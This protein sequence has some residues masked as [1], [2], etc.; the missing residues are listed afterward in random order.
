MT[1]ALWC[2]VIGGVLVVMAL[3]GSVVRRLPLSAAMLYMGIGYGLGPAGA[4][5]LVVDPVADAR[6][7]EH[8]TE[9]AV[10]VSLFTAGL[11]LRAPLSDRLWRIPVLLA[12]ASMAVGVGLVAA[13]AV[14]ALGLPV[15]AAV[16]LGAVLAPTDPVLAADVQ[17]KDAG[18]RDELRFSLTAEAGLNDGT[19]FPFVMLGLGLLGLHDLGG[20]WWRWWTIDVAWAAAAGLG[21][22]FGLGTL[23]ARVV[24]YLRKTH[25]EAVG[26]D[27]FLAL[28]LLGLAYGAAVLL[29]AWGFLS[30]FAAGLAL[31]REEMRHTAA[32][33]VEEITSGSEDDAVHPDKAPMV[34]AEAV[35][36]FNEQVEKVLEVAAVLVLGALLAATRPTWAAAGLAATLFLVVRPASVFAG[37][38]PVP[39]SA[40]RRWL[41]GWFGVRGVGSLYYSLT[42]PAMGYRGGWPG[43]WP[44]WWCGPSPCRSSCMG[45]RSHRRWTGT[46]RG[47]SGGES[48]KR[49]DPTTSPRSRACSSVPR[50]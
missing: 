4:G 32:W 27:N 38:A 23:V 26:L 33:P 9:L 35:L 31:R 29:G 22:G 21:V 42:P 12:T 3:A 41:A 45:C 13:V 30:A 36:R 50:G 10:I 18:D 49:P 28:G 11:K 43:P 15:G 1:F 6:F 46:P 24:L 39:G 19:A 47:P 5:L 7:L 48:V 8:L 25:R 34:M 40:V 37:L 14:F 44:T 17:V 20:F 2:L 16:L